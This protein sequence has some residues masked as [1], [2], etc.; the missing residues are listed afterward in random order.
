MKEDVLTKP[1]IVICSLVEE[2]PIANCSVMTCDVCE[3][4]V[5]VSPSSED[6]LA[7]HPA[8]DVVCNECAIAM[9]QRL[10][11]APL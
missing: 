10:E 11:E 9:V 4:D 7:T 2:T 1:G 5:W 8:T 3:R 6:Y